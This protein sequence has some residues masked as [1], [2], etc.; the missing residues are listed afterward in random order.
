MHRARELPMTTLRTILGG[1]FLAWALMCAACG[2]GGS[3]SGDGTLHGTGGDT[4]AGSGGNGSSSGS[5]TEPAALDEVLAALRA[6]RDG[7]MLDV[8]RAYGWPAEVE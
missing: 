7:A 8:S 4:G 1:S 3:S 6:D 5:G 2:G